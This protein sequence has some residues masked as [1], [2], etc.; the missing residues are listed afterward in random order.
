VEGTS[1]TV[2]PTL[3]VSFDYYIEYWYNYTRHMSLRAAACRSLS[4]WLR[5]K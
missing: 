1:S 2:S 4:Y 5:S 3:N